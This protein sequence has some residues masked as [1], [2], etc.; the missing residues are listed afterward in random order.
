MLASTSVEVVLSVQALSYKFDNLEPATDYALRIKV[1]NL[2][3][4]S[5][6]TDAVHATTGIEPTRPGLLTFEA[7][8]RTTLLVSWQSLQGADTGGST[9]SPLEITLYHL[10][11]QDAA[12][13]NSQIVH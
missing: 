1:N 7:S 4:E 3:G 10:S 9:L 8:T 6:W 5:D 11:V 12:T 2:V 13:A